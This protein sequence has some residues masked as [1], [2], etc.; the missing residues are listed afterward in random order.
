[1]LRGQQRPMQ[2]GETVALSD[3]MVTV[4]AITPEGRP[5]SVTVRFTTALEEPERVWLRA[6]DL[7]VSAW[8]P[9]AVGESVVVSTTALPGW[10]R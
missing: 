3:M 5:Q 9:P 2:A 10:A 4:D 8:T 1:M 7:E 6:V